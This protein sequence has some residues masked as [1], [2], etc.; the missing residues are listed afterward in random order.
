MPNQAKLDALYID[1]ASRI[2]LMSHASRSKVG[3][4]LVK[5]NNIISYGWNGTPAGMDNECEEKEWMSRDAAAGLSPAEIEAQWPYAS[6]EH[7]AAGRF[8]L[9]TKPEVAHSE[10]NIIGKLARSGGP[11]ADGSTLY[12]TLSPCP[13]CAVLIK[14]SGIVRVV[15]RDEYRLPGGVEMLRKLGVQVEKF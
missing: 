14:Q 13:S 2:A 9:V 4:V 5:D 7:F 8:R 12:C 15:Y 1:L 10:V 11:G 6:T 3:G